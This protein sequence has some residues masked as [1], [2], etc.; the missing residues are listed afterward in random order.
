[1]EL[2]KSKLVQWKNSEGKQIVWMVTDKQNLGVVVHSDG[3]SSLGTTDDLSSITNLEPYIG[4]INIVS[5]AN[6]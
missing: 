4:T 2:E 1:M 6:N 3:L 5:T